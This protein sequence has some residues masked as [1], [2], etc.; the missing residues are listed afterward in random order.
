MLQW[1]AM[2]FALSATDL[3][4]VCRVSGFQLCG[5]SV[6]RF[7]ELV[8]LGDDDGERVLLRTFDDV[9]ALARRVENEF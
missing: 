1:Q 4:R 6:Y 2:K 8:K 9:Y 7:L 5:D 3:V